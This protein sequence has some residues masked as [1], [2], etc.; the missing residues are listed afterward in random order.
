MALDSRTITITTSGDAGTATGSATISNVVGQVVAAGVAYSSEPATTDV[1]IT[2]IGEG[3]TETPILTL[4]NS[5]TD[6]PVTNLAS[7]AIDAAGAA[8]EANPVGPYVH[9]D[10]RIN[11]TGGDDAGT[12]TVTLIVANDSL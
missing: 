12:V 4:T 2:F 5:N 6:V 3:G 7:D 1:V 8:E 10:I 9:G 11:I